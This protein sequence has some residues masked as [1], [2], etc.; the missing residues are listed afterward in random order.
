MLHVGSLAVRFL[1]LGT[2]VSS[3]ME[4]DIR[5]YLATQ[6]WQ[7]SME[8]AGRGLRREKK[9]LPDHQDMCLRRR[10]LHFDRNGSLH[11]D[12]KA[13]LTRRCVD[14]LCPICVL[15][16]DFPCIRSWRM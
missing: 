13:T 4:H 1:Y 10:G 8:Q 15:A 9:V 11:T 6:I 2:L 16:L 7:A 14:S 12:E 3:A 5:L